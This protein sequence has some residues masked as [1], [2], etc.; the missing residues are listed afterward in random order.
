M[1]HE[2]EILKEAMIVQTY[3]FDLQID[4]QYCYQNHFR[5]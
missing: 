1:Q 2:P 3:K 5:F 4:E